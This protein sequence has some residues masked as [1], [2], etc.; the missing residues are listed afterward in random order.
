MEQ[1]Q[2]VAM[3]DVPIFI[4][5]CTQHK[6]RTMIERIISDRDNQRP[7]EFLEKIDEIECL[8]ESTTIRFSS[9]KNIHIFSGGTDLDMYKML[10]RQNQRLTEEQFAMAYAE[11]IG[12]QDSSHGPVYNIGNNAELTEMMLNKYV[13]NI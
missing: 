12:I 13:L 4:L 11:H 8:I 3:I 1:I 2:E 6:P 5:F 10:L 9:S 7:D